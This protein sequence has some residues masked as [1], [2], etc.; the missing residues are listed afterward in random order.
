LVRGDGLNLLVD[1]GR[2]VVMRLAAAGTLPLFLDAVLLTHLHS[3]H[4][5]DLNDVVTT[6]WVMSPHP[7]PLEV[8]GPPGT[9]AVVQGLL[10]MLGPDIGYRLAHHDDL[11][12]PPGIIVHEVTPG[13]VLNIGTATIRIGATD[14]RPVEPTVAYR[15]EVEGRSVVLAGDGVP[16]DTLD[17]LLVGADAYVQ[18]VL[19]DDLVRL[20][21]NPRF[22]DILDYHST[23]AQAAET[24]QRAGVGALI[25]TH[26]VPPPPLG[27]YDE[28]RELASA[29]GGTLVTGDDLTT[30]DLTPP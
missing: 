16:C 8:Y 11:N 1:A 18:T 10:Q 2:G 9:A 12:D 4:I 13:Q 19:R 25:L 3:D 26:F 27:Q 20:V 21:P 24:A 7:L 17:E 15:V 14:H 6:R 22:Q 30:F 23:V 29:F 28:W 5:C